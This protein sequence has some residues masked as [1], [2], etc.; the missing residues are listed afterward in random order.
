[1]KRYVALDG[2]GRS[3]ITVAAD[4]EQEAAERIREHPS[5]SLR[6]GL[7]RPGRRVYLTQWLEGS[8]RVV[9]KPATRK[10]QTRGGSQ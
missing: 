8:S 4:D 1:M 5:T 2:R 3:I 7:D 9:E 10:P 6:A